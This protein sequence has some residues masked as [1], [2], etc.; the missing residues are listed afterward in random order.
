[1]DTSLVTDTKKSH[2]SMMDG[3][4]VCRRGNEDGASSTAKHERN[5]IGM[6]TIEAWETFYVCVLPVF[7][8]KFHNY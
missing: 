4:C 5:D 1:M 7:T 8:L 6:H 2:E 3:R